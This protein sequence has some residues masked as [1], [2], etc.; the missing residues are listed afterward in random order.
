[1]S[2]PVP[3]PFEGAPVEERIGAY[4]LERRL[5]RGGMGEVFLAHDER[6]GRRVAI[7]RVRHGASPAM[8]ERFRREARAAARLNHSAVVQIYDVL[9]DGAGDAIVMEYAEGRTLREVLR[10]GL[11]PLALTVRLAREIAEGLAAAHGAGLVHRDLKAEN[12]IVTPEGHAKVLDFGLAKPM[13]ERSEETLTEHGMVLGTCHAMSPEQA[14]GEELD[15]RS[16]LFSFGVLLYE[17]LTGRSPFLGRTPQESLKRV[18]T[19]EPPPIDALR[20]DLP[21]RLAAL[22]E[23]L[24]EKNRGARPHSARE[25]AWILEEV[26]ASPTLANLPAQAATADGR[27]GELA[28]AVTIFEEGRSSALRPLWGWSRRLALVAGLAV[29]ALGAVLLLGRLRTESLRGPL[30]VAVLQPEVVPPEGGDLALVASGVLVSTLSSL[31]ALEGLAPLDP[32]QVDSAAA[33]PV[34]AARSAAADEVLAATLEN[35]G[36]MGARLSLRRIQ[37]S[38]GRVL[39]TDSFVVPT[40]PRDLRLLADAV[41][42]HLR[43][44]YPDRDLREGTPALDVRDEDYARFLRFK[45]RVDQGAIPSQA[46]LAE[47]DEILRSSPRFLEAHLLAAKVEQ[48]LFRSTRDPVH[49]ERGNEA[50]RTARALAPGDP[51]PLGVEL[52]LAL[53]ANR[54]AQARALL[55][56]LERLLPGDPELLTLSGQVA[57]SEGNLE[58]A[59]SDLAAAVERIPSWSNLYRLAD[60]EA[61]AGRNDDAR[62]HLEELLERTPGNLWGLDRLGNLELLAGDP[63]RAER[64]YLELLRR[65]PQRSHY[66]NLGLARMLLGRPAEAVEAY[67]KALELAPGHVAVLL[68]LADA[69]LDLGRESEA[70]SLYREALARLEESEASAGLSPVDRMVKAQCLARLGRRREAVAQ[71]QRTLRDGSEEPEVLYLASLVYALAGDRSSSLVNAEMALDKG[72]QPRW[73]TLSAFNSLR[74]DPDFQALLRR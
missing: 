59:I 66:T 29:L 67:R 38:D 50:V 45:L 21:G 43:R 69:E 3:S 13:A 11:P 73:F 53:A 34:E 4:R 23:R 51:R 65:Q 28:T 5:G 68:N 48:N 54:P 42:V 74:G 71:A 22:V 32:A 37:G 46:E 33:S 12:V 10:N 2:E 31:T 35:Q 61:R 25:V 19:D 56:E 64:I 39:W 17:M 57:E 24:L 14:C 70:R 72:V 62:W 36:T 55:T 30:R 8:R 49:L 7:K 16:D 26:A 41:A 20:P 60:L 44:A 63:A 9:E 1:M 40:D 6:L 15:A 52:R 47:L 18:L 27:M 58:R